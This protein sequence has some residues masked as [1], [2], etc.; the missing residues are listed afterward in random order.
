MNA[1]GEEAVALL[2]RELDGLPAG[3]GERRVLLATQL[4]LGMLLDALVST[5]PRASSARRRGCPATRPPSAC[6]SA[7]WRSSAGAPARRE[8][9]PPRR[10]RSARSKPEACGTTRRRGRVRVFVSLVLLAAD[11]DKDAERWL[12]RLAAVAREDGAEMTLGIAELG[13]GRVWRFRVR[14][15][16]R[17]RPS[18]ARSSVR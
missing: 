3:A 9:R 12:E 11:R 8:R 15:R 18:S 16:P 10:P 14:S 4:G 2:E 13:L 6:C 1:R 17:A 7:R 5:P